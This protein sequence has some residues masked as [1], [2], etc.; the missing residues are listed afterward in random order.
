MTSR[1]TFTIVPDPAALARAAANR[2][3]EVANES[4]HAR[5][6]FVVALAGGS[7]PQAMHTLLAGGLLPPNTWSNT[8]I[9]F[10][11]ERCVPPDDPR[12]NFASAHKTLLSRVPIPEA[13]IHRMQGELAPALAAD[14]Y[15]TVLTSSFKEG[16]T[17]DLIFLGMG[18]DGHTLSLFPGH[19]FAA[20]RGRLAV[21]ALAPP[22][23]PVQD[24]ITL[25]LDAVSRARHAIFLIAGQDKALTLATV[26]AAR[27]EGRE[28]YPASLITCRSGVEW[29]IDRAAA[30]PA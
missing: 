2:F 11:D 18:A 9:Y 22:Q 28:D 27:P 29:L 14:R 8:F 30:G 10:G 12:S 5:G 21:T 23:S 7:T 26:R 17:F 15:H 16:E 1:D 13:Q 19:D 25:T 3:V 6:R 20:D 4:I 24:R